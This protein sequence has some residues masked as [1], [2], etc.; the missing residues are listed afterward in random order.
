MVSRPCCRIDAHTDFSTFT[1]HESRT[2]NHTS[3]RTRPFPESRNEFRLPL[4]GEILLLQGL[5]H[6]IHIGFFVIEGDGDLVVLIVGF[7]VG[8]TLNIL[9]DRPYPGGC[10]W[11]NASRDLELDDPFGRKSR[12]AEGKRQKEAC[13]KQNRGLL[14]TIHDAPHKTGR[15]RFPS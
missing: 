1:N 3:S 13:Q 8:H 10:A 12:L 7:H 6:L 15:S 14:F 4:D 2:T 11:S 5:D 9:Q